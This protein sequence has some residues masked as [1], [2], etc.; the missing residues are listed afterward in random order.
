M[1]HS[2]NS[3]LGDLFI[4]HCIL[5]QR[6]TG[7]IRPLDHIGLNDM[8]KLVPMNLAALGVE[9]AQGQLPRRSTLIWKAALNCG[10]MAGPVTR[11][12]AQRRPTTCWKTSAPLSN[13]C[14]RMKLTSARR[15]PDAR[16]AK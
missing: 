10:S 16:R 3:D 14:M 6:R 11:I 8:I 2:Q 9:V 1:T 4:S 15:C 7:I 13:L 12:S 5:Q